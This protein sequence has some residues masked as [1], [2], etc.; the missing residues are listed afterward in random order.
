MKRRKRTGIISM[1]FFGIAL[2]LSGCGGS[3][4]R[5][6]T[7]TTPASTNEENNVV[8]IP[9]KYEGNA[10]VTYYYK[11][12]N[13]NL[14]NKTSESVKVLISF[15]E[16]F[17]I[18]EDNP[19]SLEIYTNPALG[20]ADKPGLF[21]I[22]SFINIAIDSSTTIQ[23]QYW[24][25]QT[26]SNGF[27]GTLTDRI[28][29]IPTAIDKATNCMSIITLNFL[30]E[31]IMKPGAKMSAHLDGQSISMKIDGELDY[32]STGTVLFTIELQALK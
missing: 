18:L 11:D 15:N 1:L 12:F 13:G 4:G 9:S 8:S 27:E 31:K 16:P 22:D 14:F 30:T 3:G 28:S 5:S 17:P 23:W 19:F 7:T 20:I 6:T 25:F 29:N 10:I 24:S 21:N 2:I 32:I 26:T